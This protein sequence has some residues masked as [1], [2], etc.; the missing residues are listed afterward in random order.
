M[1]RALERGGLLLGHNTVVSA[2]AAAAASSS[3]SAPPP[4]I[5]MITK[6]ERNAF[7]DLRMHFGDRDFDEDCYSFYNLSDEELS[8]HDEKKKLKIK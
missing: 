1:N 4:P 6:E 5:P 8:E 7:P 3:S 2:P